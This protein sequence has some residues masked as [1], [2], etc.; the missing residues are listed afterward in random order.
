M[1]GANNNNALQNSYII[2]LKRR[3]LGQYIYQVHFETA[4][5]E[6]AKYIIPLK[7]KLKKIIS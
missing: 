1:T 2:K 4:C 3:S 5:K 6:I 7:P